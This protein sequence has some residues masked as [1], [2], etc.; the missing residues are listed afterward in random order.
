MNF[1]IK[2][3]K[4]CDSRFP[5]CH[6]TCPDYKREKAENEARMDEYRKQHTI[7]SRL[8]S[9]AIGTFENA[10]KRMNCGK[11]KKGIKTR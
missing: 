8:T 7:Q 2:C 1:V 6:G 11:R 5:G 9:H 3:C 10:A 4:G